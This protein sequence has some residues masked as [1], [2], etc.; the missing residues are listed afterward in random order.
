MANMQVCEGLIYILGDL[1]G[2]INPI[3]PIFIDIRRKSEIIL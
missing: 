1:M 2:D 3:L